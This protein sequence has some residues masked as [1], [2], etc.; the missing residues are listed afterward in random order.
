MHRND[1][2]AW[3]VLLLYNL[4]MSWPAADIVEA[5]EEAA[6]LAGALREAGHAVT[7][8]PA[9]DADLA[10]R[11]R[12]FDPDKV[13]VLNI[14]EEL[15]GVP[16]SEALVPLIL[17]RL[18]FVYTGTP[19]E[20][21]AFS[22]DKVQVNRRLDAHGLPTP[23]WAVYESADPDGWECFPAIVKPSGEHSS[24]GITSESVVYTRADL[25]RR[26]AYVLEEFAQ[27]A[28]VEDF[29]DGR[30][31]RVA[32]WGNGVVRL[33]PPA[34]MDLSAFEDARE[35]LCTF[36]SKF[37]PG[38]RH[39]EQI[40]VRMPAPLEP[41]EYRLLE[42]VALKTYRVCGCRDYARL[43]IRLRDGI[44]YV[45]DVNPNA[46]FSRGTSVAEM[47]QAAG[48]S[49]AA[50]ASRLVQLAAQRHPLGGRRRH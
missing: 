16:H 31:F 32:L 27:P 3:P 29:I 14:C 22:W 19:A 49:Y 45:L 7:V 17:E 1:S 9:Q 47:A 30:E 33:L 50:M 38:S 23:R 10:G 13:I 4:D 28:L 39:Y 8:V 18:G 21:L 36:D 37:H 42:Q 48:Y 5:E 15:P 35:R 12:R 11:L 24:F 6:A 46:D 40:Q 20:A 43:D 41:A 25:C 2:A 44:F 26:I 34:E